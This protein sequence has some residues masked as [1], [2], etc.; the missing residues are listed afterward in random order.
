[1]LRLKNT[2]FL[3]CVLSVVSLY[4]HI[5][6]AE[7]LS[8]DE[9]GEEYYYFLEEEVITPTKTPRPINKAPAIVMV[10]TKQQIK[11]MGAQTIRDVLENIPGLG[12]TIMRYGKYEIEV[13]GIKTDNSEK[14]LFM[15]DGHRVNNPI[16]GGAGYSFDDIIVDN[17]ERI[18][19]VKGPGSA[20]YGTGAFLATINIITQKPEDIN[21]ARVELRGGSFNTA[22]ADLLFGKNFGDLGVV[23]NVDIL[24]SDGPKMVVDEDLATVLAQPTNAPGK[25]N[26]WLGKKDFSLNL[27]YKSVYWRNR[28]VDK[29]RGDFVGVAYSLGDESEINVEQ[30]YSLLG[31]QHEI[32]PKLDIKAEAYIDVVKFDILWKLYPERFYGNFP[33][34]VLGRIQVKNKT[35]GTELQLNYELFTQNMLTLGW[36]YE[37]IKQYD[38][39]HTANFDPNTSIPNLV[40]LS[41][42]QDAPNWN[43]NV[44]RKVWAL[45]AQD[46]WN[47]TDEVSLTLGSRF[48]DYSD[49]GTTLNPRGGVTWQ[50][51]KT[52]GLKLLYGKAF[53]APSFEQLYNIN[54]PSLLGNENLRAEKISTY[55]AEMDYQIIPPLMLRVNYFYNRI[56]DLIATTA[57]SSGQL[58]FT[59]NEGITKVDGIE[60]ELRGQMSKGRY[61][62]VNYTLINAKD[63]HGDRIADVAPHRGNVGLNLALTQY[64]NSNTRVLLM[65]E[66]SRAKGDT[67]PT[68]DGYAVLNQSVIVKNFLDDFEI[69][70]TV[71]NL[72]N[73]KYQAPAPAATIRNDYPNPGINFLLETRYLFN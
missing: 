51:T 64:L 72:F 47:I 10:V 8:L 1:M 21:G 29:K 24:D 55:E 11:E 50:V 52:L 43:Q 13:R 54:N 70:L 48:D 61:G 45:Y 26:S 60:V 42:F 7:D 30:G 12:I 32:S 35:L 33:D 23:G 63:E 38:V 73:T 44:T 68:L 27:K 58:Q 19:I 36:N 46:T 14:V 37:H 3:I 67:R 6:K 20:L 2:V 57:N 28:Y 49:F 4:P 9:V 34:G 15:I 40:P 16:L 53:R 71:F 5:G 39:K 31:V 17:I 18:E 62:Y 22:G 56:T 65:G 66:K 69:Q 59:N 25:T 41:S